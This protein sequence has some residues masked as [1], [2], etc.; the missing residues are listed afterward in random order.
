VVNFTGTR[1]L[2]QRKLS[3]A[4]APFTSAS[5]I[6]NVSIVTGIGSGFA[7]SRAASF[8]CL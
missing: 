8:S 2:S 6:V 1:V 5:A 3:V 4:E 7:V